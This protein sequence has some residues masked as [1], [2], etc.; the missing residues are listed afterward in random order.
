MQ[1]TRHVIFLPAASLYKYVFIGLYFKK[2][3]NLFVTTTYVLR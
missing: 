1:G 3:M 2:V